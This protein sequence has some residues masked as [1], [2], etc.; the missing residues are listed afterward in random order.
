MH[1]QSISGA[2]EVEK[3]YHYL[4]YELKQAHYSS[5]SLLSPTSCTSECHETWEMQREVRTLSKGR[6]GVGN[7]RATAP[8]GKTQNQSN[9]IMTNFRRKK[10]EVVFTYICIYIHI[11]VY[12]NMHFSGKEDPG[13]L[14]R[15]HF[16]YYG[17]EDRQY[18]N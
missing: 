6:T 8:C 2:W 1:L 4:I 15:S 10:K 16:K 7:T 13:V 9:I 14:L 11:F 17:K 18:P 3:K 12:T 5:V